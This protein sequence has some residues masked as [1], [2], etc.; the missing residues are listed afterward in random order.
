MAKANRIDPATKQPVAFDFTDLN[1]V[2]SYFD[3]V[4]HPYEEQGWISGGLTGSRG[5]LPVGRSGSSVAS[6][7]LSHAGCGKRRQ[8]AADSVTVFGCGRPSLSAGIFRGLH[9]DLVQ[10]ALSTPILRRRHPWGIH[11]VVP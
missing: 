11:L 8:D 1:F 10:P 9:R 2:K 6:E 3:L 7:S 4:L 5:Y